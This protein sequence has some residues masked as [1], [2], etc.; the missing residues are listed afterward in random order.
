MEKSS[1]SAGRTEAA[2]AKIVLT[3]DDE[4]N[5]TY[6]D[7]K[8]P[9]ILE[10]AIPFLPSGDLGDMASVNRACRRA[11]ISSYHKRLK[12]PSSVLKHPLVHKEGDDNRALTTIKPILCKKARDVPKCYQKF[13]PW[14]H[15]DNLMLGNLNQMTGMH[16]TKRSTVLSVVV[17]PF[18]EESQ[19]KI[20]WRS[21]P[22]MIKWQQGILK[23][24]TELTPQQGTKR[25]HHSL[26]GE[27]LLVIV[28]KKVSLSGNHQNAQNDDDSY[29]QD[30]A[31]ELWGLLYDM[32][33]PNEEDGTYHPILVQKIFQEPKS[34]E[35]SANYDSI[36]FGECCRS[37]NGNVIALVTA[38]PHE[39]YIEEGPVEVTVLD[40][41]EDHGF[42]Q[43]CVIS[44]ETFNAVGDCSSVAL[45]M[46]T[47]GE[48]L[49]VLNVEKY[50][51]EGSWTVYDIRGGSDSA[52][53]EIVQVEGFALDDN[54][55]YFTPDNDF[56][57]YCPGASYE[58]RNGKIEEAEFPP[59]ASRVVCHIG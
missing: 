19:W 18:E 37:G 12:T 39:E 41:K 9:L 55:A 38:I 14:S 51:D 4:R 13:N 35:W 40:I 59:F 56:V 11:A 23:R 47:G 36:E 32:S 30:T 8:L 43:R 29:D 1:E 31:K 28:S 50:N 44:V 42:V 49:S 45:S 7:A 58:W 10:L 17:Y 25:C 34:I 24:P 15:L 53:Q 6:K 52:P 54:Y 20:E 26:R 21:P 46:S 2:A 57:M 5:L 16:A 27:S 33:K 3:N 22:M 48:I